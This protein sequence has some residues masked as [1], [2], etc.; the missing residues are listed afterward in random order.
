MARTATDHP[1]LIPADEEQRLEAVR[2]YAVLD[3]PPDAAFDRIATLA[4]RI[5]HTPI[6]SVTIVDEDRIWF[7]ARHG[8]DATETDRVPGLCA[9]AILK[10]DPT[11]VTDAA[12]DPSTISNPL[13]AG[14]PGLRFY[15]AAPCPASGCAG[16]SANSASSACS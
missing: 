9:S 10:D 5:L 8:L 15:A 4:A 7:R 3:T 16:A 11:I 2:R 12:V 13:V 1:E 6:A 14:D